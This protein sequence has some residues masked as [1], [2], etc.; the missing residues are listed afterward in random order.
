MFLIDVAVKRPVLTTVIILFVALM[1]FLSYFNLPLNTIPEVEM[2]IVMVQV[3]YPGA[4][5]EEIESNI[6][7]KIEDELSTIAGIDYVQSYLM[8]NVNITVCMF[9]TGKDPDI[10][11]QEVKDKIDAIVNDFPDGAYQ[12][13]VLKMDINAQAVIEMAFVSGLSDKD[14]FD[15]ADNTLKDKFAK[16]PGVSKV[17]L[18][19]GRKREIQIIL[20]NNTLSKYSLSPLQ[21]VGFLASNNLNI[22]GGNIN[23]N[24]SEYSVKV[25]GEYTNIS[26]I[27]E[28]KVPTRYGIKYL[29]DIAEIKDTLVKADS[30]S[31]FYTYD[32]NGDAINKV[33]KM[34]VFK[35]S[36]ANTVKVADGV[37]E[38]L[39][40]I[41]SSL[42]ENSSLIVV[43]D[44][45]TFIKNSVNDTMSTIY[46][47]IILTSLILYLFLHS[48]KITFIIAI[49]MPVTLIATFLLAD[50]AGFSLNVF[51]LMALSVSV[52]TLTTNSVVIIENIIRHMKRGEKSAGASY[53]GTMEIVVAVLASTLT[54]IVVFVPLASMGSMAGQMFKEFGLMVTF[55]MIFSIIMGFTLTPMLA[56]N[57]L[58]HYKAKNENKTGFSAFFDRYFDK[59]TEAYRR[60][61]DKIIRKKR[62]RYMAMYLPFVLL[63][64]TFWFI[65][66]VSPLGSEFMP[67]MTSRKIQIDVEM[68]NYYDINRTKGIFEEIRKKALGLKEAENVLIEVGNLGRNS[69]GYL[70][71]IL[72]NLHKDKYLERSTEQVISEL[73]TQ[74]LDF[75]DASIKVKAASDFEGPG[76]SSP[77]EFQISGNDQTK[78]S[79]LT[80]QVLE[81]VKNV[82]G[83]TNVDSDIRPGKPEV[84]IIPDK[85][86]LVEYGTDVAS[87]AQVVRTSVEGITNT[88]LKEKGI[89]YDIRI[90]MDDSTIDDLDKISNLTVLTPKG[91]I[92]ISELAKLEFSKSPSMI[93]R[94]DKERQYK[95]TADT[96]GRSTGEINADVWEQINSTITIPEGCSIDTGFMTK[97]QKEMGVEFAKAALIAVILT[98][99]LIAGILESYRQSL[100]I[101][102]T[103]PLALLGVIW[104]LKITGIAMNLFA[105][106]AGVMLI[107]IVVNNAILILDYANILKNEGHSVAD[108]IVN[109][110]ATKLKA[111]IMATLASV[112]GMLPLALGIGEA[113]AMQQG[114]GIVSLFGLIITAVF[115]QFTI[116]A[117]YASF[118]K[119]KHFK[120]ITVETNKEQ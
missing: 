66:K 77:I 116:P 36:D 87:I 5:P 16:I 57:F 54:N 8:E 79:E 120:R 108:S 9:I 43:Q 115:T 14:A 111:I 34:S 55:V 50:W 40:T 37:M 71:R 53:K 100:L 78:L 101:M 49:S 90:Q 47:G 86:K 18:A 22:P 11:S 91:S 21:I 4:S 61:L 74:L 15:Y 44:R 92:K 84:K 68:P 42:P 26:E 76:S 19:G 109:A 38:Q 118:M 85:R 52:G 93:T 41:R 65:A 48:F 29:K 107:G 89:E 69:G 1:G 24:G 20:D 32:K 25:Y 96:K 81:I 97:I 117:F 12:P 98:F 13:V 10:A 2:P 67:Q 102:I 110:S 56:T 30:Y 35:Q 17:E 73:Q 64:A 95:V 33:I 70:G 82:P 51:T 88:K 103:V 114:M 39:E 94:K 27:E 6:S 58:K 45:S 59:F 104:S 63:L 105:M 106:M 46:M 83:T 28:I 62:Y 99:L 3:V 80:Y 72:V 7:K 60:L 75:P 119:D 112:F 23:K 113:A 31:S